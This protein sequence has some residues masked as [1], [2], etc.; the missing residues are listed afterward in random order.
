[1]K[2]ESMIIKDLIPHID[3]TYRTI[4]GREHRWIG[5]MSM[6]GGGCLALAFT[7][8]NLFSSVLA[9]APGGVRVQGK[10][11]PDH[12]ATIARENVEKLGQTRVRIVSGEKDRGF[13]G[14]KAFHAFLLDLGVSSDFEAIPNI[15][16]DMTGMFKQVGIKGLQF[17][18]NSEGK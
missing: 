18:S 5:G 17:H 7:Y 16:H 4:A 1:M 13:E 11:K 14:A 3:A 9:Y 6:G 10:L 8:P 15:G 12:V 2:V